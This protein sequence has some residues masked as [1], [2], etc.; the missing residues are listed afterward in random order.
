MNIDRTVALR[1]RALLLV[2]QVLHPR[3]GIPACLGGRYETLFVRDMADSTTQALREAVNMQIPGLIEAAQISIDIA[4][5]YKGVNHDEI[6]GEEKDRR[7]HEIYLP[8]SSPSQ[9]RRL[10]MLGKCGMPV[11][12]DRETG[13]LYMVNYFAGDANGKLI[14]AVLSVGEAVEVTEG[15][16][17]ADEYLRKL[18]P[19]IKS[20]VNH[21]LRN[22]KKYGMGVV[23]TDPKNN[24]GFEAQ[25][26]GDGS[27]R[28]AR[29]DGTRLEKG[30]KIFYSNAVNAVKGYESAAVIAER[31]GYVKQA[32][33]L[34]LMSEEGREQID[35]LF[36]SDSM[37]TYI[38][39]ID[40]NGK[41]EIIND[42]PIDGIYCGVV[43][44]QKAEMV[45][46]RLLEPDMLTRYGIRTRSKSS[47]RY[48]ER[49]FLAYQNGAI[50][51]NRNTMAVFGMLNYGM[52]REAEVMAE[53]VD[54]YVEAAGFRELMLCTRRDEELRA[55]LERGKEVAPSV[56]SWALFGYLGV[57]AWVIRRHQ[58][59]ETQERT[60]QFSRGMVA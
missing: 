37:Q 31:L 45:I 43:P 4:D 9:K 54:N 35:N 8:I 5:E 53:A 30:E 42:D 19:E 29:E 51:P 50:W 59:Q 27:G 23:V 38:P 3:L 49:G 17:R 40:K 52:I 16:S 57:S 56:Q 22:T 7:L 15:R 10:K 60:R 2:P 39:A 1:E 44:E 20:A 41:F 55:Y 25:T 24:C 33:D 58:E 6:S 47:S 12:K 14:Q 28:Y 18:W 36:W 34:A 13:N 21:D 46:G 11:K 26:W 32:R 48:T